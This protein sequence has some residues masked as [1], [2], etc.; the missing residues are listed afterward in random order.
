M[1]LE[2]KLIAASII[3]ISA[4]SITYFV[5]PLAISVENSLATFLLIFNFVVPVLTTAALNPDINII[6]ISLLF[7]CAATIGIAGFVKL[8]G[9]KI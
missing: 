8:L 4:L 2:Q 9:K 1:K 3:T 6:Q 5:P 7:F